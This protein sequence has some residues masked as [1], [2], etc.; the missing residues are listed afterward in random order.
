M[1]A[2]HIATT[3]VQSD[4]LRRASGGLTYLSR[5]TLIMTEPKTDKRPATT[6][7]LVVYADSVVRVLP[8]PKQRV[9]KSFEDMV[10]F[11]FNNLK[12]LSTLKDEGRE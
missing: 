1:L 7:K 5:D 2:L 4:T 11:H 8:L 12:N 9:P 10:R 3:Q 6:L